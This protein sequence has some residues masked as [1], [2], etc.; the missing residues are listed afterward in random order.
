MSLMP[1]WVLDS[2]TYP[3]CDV[4]GLPVM[5]KQPTHTICGLARS[6][7][8]HTVPQTFIVGGPEDSEEKS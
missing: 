5:S 1:R 6:T 3:D 7:E 2:L 8:T 4:C